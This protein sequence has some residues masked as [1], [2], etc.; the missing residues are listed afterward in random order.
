MA[1]NV[2]RKI[3][4]YEVVELFT[5]AFNRI[6]NIE[7]A[8]NGLRAAGI[9]P[10]DTTKFDE[11]FVDAATSSLEDPSI[12]QR[13]VTPDSQILPTSIGQQ[14]PATPL[15]NLNESIPLTNIVNVLI[16]PQQKSKQTSRKKHS[17]V[18]TSTPMKD[19]LEE[20]E[21][22]K[23]YKEQIKE[24]EKTVNTSKGKKE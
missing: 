2:G 22:K 13:A 17:T 23:K 5:K 1:S 6:R 3:T 16:M 12:L 7:K 9:W 19:S 4:Q 18:T 10:I 8:A 11:Q 24:T 15:V 21:Q 20:K 14:R